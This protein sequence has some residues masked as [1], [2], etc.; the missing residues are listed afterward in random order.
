M[1]AQ[2]SVQQD[3]KTEPLL[4]FYDCEAANG[5]VYYGDIIEWWFLSW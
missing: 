2:S 4:V 3:K 1:A 5:N